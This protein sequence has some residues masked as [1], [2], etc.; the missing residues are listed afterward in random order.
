[1]Q[2]IFP[3]ELG[4]L[5]D[6]ELYGV[7]M[8]EQ[9]PV[10]N[11]Y[12]VVA[13]DRKTAKGLWAINGSFTDITEVGPSVSWIWAYAAVDFIL[14]RDEWKIWHMQY[15]ED[16][17]VRCGQNWAKEAETLP[18]L[19]EFA[20]LA[21]SRLPEPERKESLWIPYSPGRPFMGT[22]RIPEPYVTFG[23]TF[24]YGMEGGL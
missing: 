8:F 14:E 24:S 7:G 23:E 11:A 6:E 10:Q 1:M 21:G 3:K 5:S 17:N 12:V 15:L 4:A 22:P 19:P 20:E 2:R 13:G 16:V 18:K 9:K